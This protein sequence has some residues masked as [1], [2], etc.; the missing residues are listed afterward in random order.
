[1]TEQTGFISRVVVDHDEGTSPDDAIRDYADNT[2]I[3]TTFEVDPEFDLP[4]YTNALIGEIAD[5][6]HDRYAGEDGAPSHEDI[7]AAIQRADEGTIWETFVG[8]CIDNI[9]DW[10]V[11]DHGL[12]R[13]AL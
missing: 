1:M 8:K 11:E 13:P 6:I 10:L 12:K 5:C 4:Y 3:A 7:H 9:E 2:D